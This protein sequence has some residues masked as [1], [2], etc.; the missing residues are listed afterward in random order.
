MSVITEGKEVLGVPVGTDS[1]IKNVVSSKI[2][3]RTREIIKLAE[4]AETHP[5]G[6]ISAF[7]HGFS[8]KWTYFCRV[9]SLIEHDL[10][11]NL[12]KMS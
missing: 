8:S 2:S 9:L 12:W 7:D 5:H 6:S 1:F 4:I 10:Q 3:R 11:R